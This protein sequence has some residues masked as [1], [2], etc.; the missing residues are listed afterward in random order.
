[1]DN[2]L[3]SQEAIRNVQEIESATVRFA[4]DSG[5]GM[6]VAGTQFTNA[7]V[8]YG[9]DISTLPDYPAE[10]RAP[11]GTVAGVSGYQINFSSRK[12]HTPGDKID[13]L[14][15]MNPAALKVNI[16][17][18]VSGGLLILNSDAFEASDLKLAGY[19]KNP[20]ED[21]GLK[22]YR[23]VPI[24]I[25]SMTRQ[26]VEGLGLDKKAAERCKNFFTL[27]LAFWVYDRPIEATVEWLKKK[28]FKRPAVL[29]ANLKS[30]Y[31][32]YHFGETTELFASTYSI[33]KAE[34]EPGLYRKVSG[35]EALA[36]GLVAA[37]KLSGKPLF[38]GSYPITPASDILHD[39][40]GMKKFGVI[41]FQAEDEIA[42]ICSAIGAS[43]GGSLAVTGTSG[44]GAALK[45]E[46]MGM[47]VM[48]ELPLVIV[49][50]QRGG[51]ST[52]L[53]TKT[54]QADLFQ[55]VY[56]RNG[57]C[58]I[59]VLAASTPADCFAMAVEAC[60]IALQYMTPVILLSDGYLANGAEPWKIPPVD[61]LPKIN[62][63]YHTDPE[64][65]QS[66][67]RNEYM[68]RPWAIPGTPGLEH[69]IG[70]LEK[71]NI[72]GNVSYDADNHELMIHLRQ[73]KIDGI[74][75]DIPLL[76]INGDTQGELLVVGWGST[77]GAI[78]T[79]V[80]RLRREG[81]PVSSAHLQYLN[82]FPEN[83]GEI[84]KSFKKI[85][86]PEMNLGQLRHLIQARYLVKTKGFSKVKGKPFQIHE[87]VEAIE[88]ALEETE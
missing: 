62:V 16:A 38:Y 41:T 36:I 3:N 18:L 7:A 82:P 75:K 57:E 87:I 33:P 47:A 84:L 86:I 35:N 1:M 8:F 14:F 76:E 46:G 23:F 52:G 60:R 59:P 74:Q 25:S 68:A 32:G 72:T 19:D 69:R 61:S 64:N 34:I 51:P 40:S 21:E 39:L 29:E 55:A 80:D 67:S 79:A 81:K 56:G 83:L 6:Q 15:A 11:V 28:F 2:K 26:A 88:N 24:P 50:V 22:K 10:I 65:Y 12:I 45:S 17:D 4:G 77:R 30:L 44:P 70:G 5:D 73:Q 53:P 54:E 37:S 13:A 63:P 49:N 27:G 78:T 71:Q 85:L 43:Y 31:A 20:L 42:A 58:P 66:Y 9:N 48:L